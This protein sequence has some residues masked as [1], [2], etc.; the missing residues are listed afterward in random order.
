MIGYELATNRIEE[1]H[2][3]AAQ[4]RLARDARRASRGDRRRPAGIGSFAALRRLV[5]G[6]GAAKAIP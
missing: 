5:P 3:D 6:A 1:L 4:D 2:R